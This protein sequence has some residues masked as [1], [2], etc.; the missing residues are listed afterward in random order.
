MGEIIRNT[1]VRATT[2]LRRATADLKA[3]DP[4]APEK[5]QA[6]G[7]PDQLQIT[8]APTQKRSLQDLLKDVDK[9]LK[10]TQS[11]TE[12][13]RTI[14]AD[15]YDVN[16]FEG[17]YLPETDKLILEDT[18]KQITE[19]APLEEEALA[20]LSSEEQAAFKELRALVQDD[21]MALLSLQ[22]LLAE[23]SL[24]QGEKSHGSKRL[25]DELTALSKATLAE[26][27][28]R[29]NLLTDTIQ[30]I[31]MPSA[32]NQTSRGTCTV[33][34]LQILMAK[35]HPAEY[36]RLIAGLASTSGEVKLANGDLI[37][38][39][40]GTEKPDDTTRSDSSRLWQPALMEYGNGKDID[41]DNAKDTNIRSDGKDL[42]MGLTMSGVKTAME[43]LLDKRV[44]SVTNFA[45]LDSSKANHKLQELYELSRDYSEDELK[46][47]TQEVE[48]GELK[49]L[50][51][52]FPRWKDEKLQA[53][54]TRLQHFTKR[55]LAEKEQSFGTWRS[56]M[57][58][59]F[60]KENEKAFEKLRKQTEAGKT[61]PVGMIWDQ[62]DTVGQNHS[63][64]EVL[65][66]KFE[67]DRVYFNNPWGLE[68]SLPLSEFSRRVIDAQL[69]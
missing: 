27:L 30:E 62:T 56:E 28:D 16:A 24:T 48:T 60:F 46:A 52:I 61:I 29:K 15:P 4:P 49:T 47:L 11:T 7:S 44:E 17:T 37:K 23:K 57:E 1:A 50:K 55:D 8:P 36:T 43:A 22:K 63:L 65:V 66:T 42:G 41:Y 68:E 13:F 25:L 45:K 54:L 40:P 31:A 53:E 19:N 51:E 12:N 10:N 3:G 33:T 14:D 18:R 6:I 35:E 67:G 38:R 2:P 69:S 20:A 64:H 59:K 5:Q 9:A 58:A 21:P 34:T 39:E 32:I 26:G